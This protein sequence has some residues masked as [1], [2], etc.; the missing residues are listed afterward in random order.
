MSKSNLTYDHLVSC[1][2]TKILRKFLRYRI[3]KSG[4]PF[5]LL[6]KPEMCNL[7]LQLDSN[8]S[9]NAYVNTH[10]FELLCNILPVVLVRIIFDFLPGY[11]TVNF[12]HQRH[13]IFISIHVNNVKYDFSMTIH[14]DDNICFELCNHI[15]HTYITHLT[16]TYISHNYFFNMLYENVYY[17]SDHNMLLQDM[18]SH[19]P[20]IAILDINVFLQI[21]CTLIVIKKA[22]LRKNRR[23]L[24]M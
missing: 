24:I 8:L 7:E 2:D 6:Q 10:V 21:F 9:Q 16:N 5:K 4:N 12:Q 15:Y 22:Y 23:C 18:N 3:G 20:C 17:N 19:L 11:I 13:I 14:N 1:Y